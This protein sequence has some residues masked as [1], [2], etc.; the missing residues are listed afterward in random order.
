MERHFANFAR[1][2]WG[3]TPDFTASKATTLFLQKLTDIHLRSHLD[4]ELEVNGNINNV[5]MMSVIGIFIILIA[6]FNFINLS[7][8]RATKRSKE[9]GLRKVVGA[10]KSQLINQ[11]LSESVLISSLALVLGIGLVIHPGVS[12]LLGHG[13]AHLLRV[14]LNQYLVFLGDAAA[15]LYVVLAILA[16]RYAPE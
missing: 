14:T 15:I 3:A 12:L 9:V 2:N 11:Y 8:A 6:C 7:T 1:T 16:V 4:D 13:S 10:F 5:R